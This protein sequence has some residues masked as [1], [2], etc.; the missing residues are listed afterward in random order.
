MSETTVFHV[1]PTRTGWEIRKDAADKS[2]RAFLNRNEARDWALKEARKAGEAQVLVHNQ[3][4]S[5]QEEIPVS[6]QAVS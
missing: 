1:Q 4:H 2:L 5:I 6:G 3:D